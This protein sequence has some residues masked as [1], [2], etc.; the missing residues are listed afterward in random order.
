ML[1]QLPTK[2]SIF[3]VL[4]LEGGASGRCNPT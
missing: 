2:K 3:F 1:V 4:L